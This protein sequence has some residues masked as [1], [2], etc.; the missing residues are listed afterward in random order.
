MRT[1]EEIKKEIER[2]EW[3]NGGYYDDHISGHISGL[4]WVLDEDEVK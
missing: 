4:E 3:I 2:L 1:I